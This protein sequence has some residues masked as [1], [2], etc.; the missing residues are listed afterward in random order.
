MAVVSSAV[1]KRRP[2]AAL[3]TVCT[4]AQA[5]AIVRRYESGL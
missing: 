2:R 1:I 3:P 5:Q 4:D